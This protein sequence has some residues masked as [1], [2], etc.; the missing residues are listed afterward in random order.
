MQTIYSPN[1]DLSLSE[2]AILTVA[3]E[4][5]LKTDIFKNIYEHLDPLESALVFLTRATKK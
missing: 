1:T 3:K 2:S 5:D 4:G